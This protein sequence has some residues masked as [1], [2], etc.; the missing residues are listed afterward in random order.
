MK[1]FAVTALFVLGLT[2]AGCGS[3]SN[4]ANINGNWN[5]TLLS[6]GNTTAFA[7]GTTLHVNGDGSVTVSSFSF[8]ETS[9]CFESDTTETGAFTLS[10]SVNGQVNGTFGMSV[11]SG[12]PA[13]NTLTLSGTAHGN[14]ITGNWTLTGS[15]VCTGT[16]TFTMTKV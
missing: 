15:A 2:L 4:P 13:G 7:F 8:T 12:T 6:T 11:Q 3:G 10:G 16:G 9:S 1:Q 14:T 5:A